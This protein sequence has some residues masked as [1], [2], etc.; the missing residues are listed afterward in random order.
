M[1]SRVPAPHRISQERLAELVAAAAYGTVL[2]LIALSVVSVRVIGLGYGVE[3][4]AGVGMSTWV[5][6]V[7]AELLAQHVHNAN[8]LRRE[9]VIA[10]LVDGSPILVAPVL[11]AVALGLGRVGVMPNE[12][13]RIL[14]ILI[15]VVQLLAVGAFVARAAPTRPKARWTFAAVTV[16]IGVVVVIVSVWLGH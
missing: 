3:L 15:G 16:G 10:A 5:A 12:A 9:Q 1:T 6:H 4:V 7:F 13:A 8:P 14:A 11:P 2:V